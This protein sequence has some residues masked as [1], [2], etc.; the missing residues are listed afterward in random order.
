MATTTTTTA[1]TTTTTIVTT[2]EGKID[3]FSSVKAPP[4]AFQTEAP[5]DEGDVE[6]KHDA[7]CGIDID[8][9]TV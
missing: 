4:V 5:D 7:A 1:T 2:I 9:M 3:S 6:D 8:K